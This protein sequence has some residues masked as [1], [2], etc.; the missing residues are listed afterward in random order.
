MVEKVY[1]E[2]GIRNDIVTMRRYR[3][4]VFVGIDGMGSKQKEKNSGVFCGMM[5][6]FKSGRVYVGGWKEISGKKKD[7]KKGKEENSDTVGV[8]VVEGC[9]HGVG[10]EI[11]YSWQN[12]EQKSQNT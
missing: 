9:K 11:K 7:G 10:L 3:N 6:H 2:M 5:W 8:Q 1:S 4:G 12:L